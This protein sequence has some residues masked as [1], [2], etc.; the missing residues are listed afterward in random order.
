MVRGN[1]GGGMAGMAHDL[2]I[3]GG[4][5][6]D[7]RGGEPVAADVAVEGTTIAAV[8]TVAVVVD[9]TSSYVKR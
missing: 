5:L 1:E 7:G 9:V 8:G 6:A 4:Y 3:R 2:V